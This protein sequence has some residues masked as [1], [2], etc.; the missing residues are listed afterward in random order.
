MVLCGVLFLPGLVVWL[1]IFQLRSLIDKGTK[2]NKRAGAL[3]TT[4]SSPWA[5]SPLSS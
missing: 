5:R 3:A 4:C 1:L 2:N